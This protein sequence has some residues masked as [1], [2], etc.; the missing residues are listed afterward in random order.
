MEILCELW[1]MHET[2][3]CVYSSKLL[4][5]NKMSQRSWH[6]ILNQMARIN[7][8][9]SPVNK[10]ETIKFTYYGMVQKQ[11]LLIHTKMWKI[12]E[13]NSMIFTDFRQ[14]EYGCSQLM[15]KM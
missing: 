6:F 15:V 11:M 13:L 1:L 7:F 2:S 9:F 14:K 12:P 10:L 4:E 5:E 8:V 3:V